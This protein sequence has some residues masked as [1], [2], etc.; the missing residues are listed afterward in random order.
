MKET[1]GHACGG[2]GLEQGVVW[3]EESHMMLRIRRDVFPDAFVD[4]LK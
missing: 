4:R 3:Y 1:E 2:G